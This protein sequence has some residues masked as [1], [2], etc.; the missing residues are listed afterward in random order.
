MKAVLCIFAV[1]LT[2]ASTTQQSCPQDPK[3]G[4]PINYLHL[5]KEQTDLHW[6][7]YNTKTSYTLVYQQEIPL[8]SNAKQHRIVFRI[9]DN[10]LPVRQW[11]YIV[12]V[13][14]DGNGFISQVGTFA[15][16][17]SDG[18]LNTDQN[19]LRIV[20]G[21]NNIALPTPGNCCLA[22]LEYINF[23]YLFAHYYKDGNGLQKPGCT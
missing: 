17:R 1:A 12:D 8:A 3:V 15:K 9:T 13:K 2:L 19:I 4:N 16:I 21:D 10:N 23:Y 20:F 5:F 6:D 7:F 11:L 22:K 18:V 14:Y